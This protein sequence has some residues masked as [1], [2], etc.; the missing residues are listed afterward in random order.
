MCEIEEGCEERPFHPCTYC[1][2]WF[3]VTHQAP[4]T[5]RGLFVDYCTACKKELDEHP[6]ER[7][8]KRHGGRPQS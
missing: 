3:C 1:G 4:G 6:D 8:G 7:P 5:G 2:R